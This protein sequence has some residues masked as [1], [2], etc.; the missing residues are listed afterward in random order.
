MKT[1]MIFLF[2]FSFLGVVTTFPLHW[3]EIVL[4]YIYIWE[5]DT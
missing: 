2:K 3:S 4:K 5:K 1:T